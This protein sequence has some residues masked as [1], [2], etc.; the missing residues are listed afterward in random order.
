M[1]G[2]YYVHYQKIPA[3]RVIYV[4]LHYDATKYFST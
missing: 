1:S 2:G 3:D 4:S